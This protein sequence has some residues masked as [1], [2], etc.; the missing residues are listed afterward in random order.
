MASSWDEEQYANARLIAAV[1]REMKMSSRDILIAIMAAMQESSLRNLNG[2]DRDSRGLFQ[3]RPSQGW[4]TVQQV[5]D[6][7]YASRKFFSALKS[8]RNRNNMTLS[9]AAQSVQKSAYPSAYADRENDARRMLNFI[10]EKGGLP[11]P[12]DTPQMD[13]GDDGIMA[14]KPEQPTIDVALQAAPA[15]VGA[16]TEDTGAAPGTGASTDPVVLPP[17]QPRPTDPELTPGLDNGF[18]ATTGLA[19]GGAR[20][21]G[22]AA[23]MKLLG[24]P[25][26]YGG[27]HGAKPGISGGRTGQG[28]DCSGLV[29]IYL[30]AAGMD[31]GQMTAAQQ[32]KLGTQTAISNL[33][34]GDL[35]AAPDGGH[36]GI[37]V[38]EGK[39]LVA[40]STGDVVKIAP[41]NRGMVGIKLSL[42]GGGGISAAAGA[43]VSASAPTVDVPQEEPTLTLA[44]GLDSIGAGA[45]ENYAGI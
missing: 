1:G 2:G 17:T 26:S 31:A 33:Q 21:A 7:I 14:V 45:I 25:Y 11:W 41:V 10:G 42:A 16:S 40:P 38:G 3:Q 15:G 43:G 34:P 44:Q 32:M 13:L 5:T 28:I 19:G 6:P 18:P 30:Q 4:G 12:I 8:V 27:G 22:I 24:T 36:I 39:M 23:A 9:Q 20:E 35:V 37:Y 29:R